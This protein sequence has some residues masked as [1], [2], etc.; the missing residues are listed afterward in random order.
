[1]LSRMPFVYLY[2]LLLHAEHHTSEF[3]TSLKKPNCV[4]KM[5]K[6]KECVSR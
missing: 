4:Q 5:A 2:V 6:N 3:H 1:M